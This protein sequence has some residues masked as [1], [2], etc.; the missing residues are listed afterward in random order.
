MEISMFRLRLC[1]I[2]A[3]LV[4]AMAA[5]TLDL[6]AQQAPGQGGGGQGGGPRGGFG[7]GGPGGF[8]GP[9][10][11]FNSLLN[12]AQNSGVQ[13][14]LKVDESQKAKLKGLSEANQKQSQ[15]IRT[16]FGMQGR[17]PRGGGPGQGGGGGRNGGAGNNPGNAGG[18][19]NFGGGGGNFGGGNAGGNFGGGNFGGNVDPNQP[20]GNGGQGPGNGRR[21]RGGFGPGGQPDPEAMQR[22]QA[23]RE[24]MNE[25]R[26]SAEQQLAK[27]LSRGQ[28]NRLRQ[29]QLQLEGPSALVRDEIAEKLNLDEFQVQ[30]IRD[31]MNER[32]QARR[33][34]FRAQGEL[35][36]QMR[37]NNNPNPNQ[38]ADN[39]GGGNN[40]G[41]PGAGDGG[42]GN[43]NGNRGNRRF[44]PEAF[45]QFMER[46]E[47][48]AKMDEFRA[49]QDKVENQFTAAVNKV[50]SPRQRAN[51]KKMLGAPFDRSKM[52]D[53]GPPGMFGRRGSG[54][55][56]AANTKGATKN[57]AAKTEDDDDDSDSG[58]GARAAK[59]ATSKPAAPTATSTK[60]R[61]KSLR[62]RRGLGRSSDD[63]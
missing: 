23:M 6:R 52:G 59:P 38:Y 51:Y 19:G 42:A 56:A 5:L 63:E 4:L 47:V 50:M 29:I 24:A 21:N 7:R 18:G 31:L 39:G 54:N 49:A 25:L 16:Q 44:D 14:D 17:G 11:G 12:L 41:N 60:P 33:E 46:P 55:Q 34:S 26:Q 15:E 35:F 20:A 37:P 45:R 3:A 9:G 2:S 61:P 28:L 22:F 62:E 43:G 27:I 57:A 30:A 32:G 8:G 1:L 58:N 10:G 53:G 36:R 13:A 48:K 40:G